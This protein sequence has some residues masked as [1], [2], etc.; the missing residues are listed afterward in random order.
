MCRLNVN[1]WPVSVSFQLYLGCCYQKGRK[2]KK[3]HRYQYV[4]FP[5]FVTIGS[6]ELDIEIFKHDISLAIF[7]CYC[8]WPP[9]FH[10]LNPLF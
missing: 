2:K 10:A 5:I 9:H 1:F 6:S 4:P 8:V 3:T 7:L